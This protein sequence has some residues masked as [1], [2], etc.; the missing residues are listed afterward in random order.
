MNDG[1]GDFEKR[2]RFMFGPDWRHR[3]A[4][5]LAASAS[6]VWSPQL[7]PLVRDAALFLRRYAAGPNHQAVAVRKF[8]LVA[9]AMLLDQN[10]AINGPLRILVLGDCVPGQI[11]GRLSLEPDAL[12]TW[13]QL[14]FDVRAAREAT[15]WIL[16]RVILPEFERGDGILASKLKCAC[17]GGPQVALAMIDADCRILEK[18]GAALFD[19]KLALYTKFEQA[20]ATVIDSDRS[21]LMFMKMHAALML[22]E[23]RMRHAEK[24]LLQ[25]SAQSLRK[26]EYSMR[27][28]ELQR[29]RMEE[30]AAR[31]ATRAAKAAAKAA[32]KARINDELHAQYLR[33]QTALARAANSP[34]ANLRWEYSSPRFEARRRTTYGA[35]QSKIGKNNTSKAA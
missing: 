6:R 9:A 11:C 10:Q 35:H 19:L 28:V 31:D 21:K 26:H 15:D 16:I 30:R 2:Q 29:R 17:A 8:P 14:F 1:P 24:R 34:L 18:Q 5:A 22:Q 32:K 33:R 13:E 23:L 12:S 7:D 3:Q 27:R 20:L 25:R 4:Q